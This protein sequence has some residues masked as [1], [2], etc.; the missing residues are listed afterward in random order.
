MRPFSLAR[1]LAI[2]TTA[3]LVAT[4]APAAGAAPAAQ[5]AADPGRWSSGLRSTSNRSTLHAASSRRRAWST[6]PPTT[7]WSRSPTTTSAR[8]CP[9]WPPSWDVSPDAK[10]FT[11]HLRQGVKFQTSGN[12]MTSADVKWSMGTRHRH[13]G[14]P[15]VPARRHHQHRNARSHDRVRSPSPT[16]DPAFIAKGSFPASLPPLDSKTVQAHGGTSGPDAKT[17]TPPRRG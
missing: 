15:V 11:F 10:T 12:P 6:R 1:S 17:P 7:R 2:L 14:Q 9:T 16:P 5:N 13:Q 3:L 8:S 4:S